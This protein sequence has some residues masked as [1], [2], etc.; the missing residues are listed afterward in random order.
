MENEAPN[1]VPAQ[2]DANKLSRFITKH[3]LAV[4]IGFLGA[5]ASIVALPIAIWF[6][7]WPTIPKGELTYAIQPVRTAFVQVSHPSD[8]TVLYKGKPIKGDLSAAQIMISNSGAQPIMANDI[9]VP[10]SIVVSNAEVL[11]CSFSTAPLSGSGFILATNLPNNHVNLGWDIF[12]HA[13]KPIIQIVYAGMRDAPIALEGRITDQAEPKEVSWFGTKRL[14]VFGICILTG[15]SMLMS[16]I[17]MIVFSKHVLP[18]IRT[19]GLSVPMFLV[20]GFIAGMV[21]FNALLLPIL[22]VLKAMGY[23][24]SPK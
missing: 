4:L 14:S 8:I 2:P 19:L 1:A 6:A 16:V 5:I 3:P 7:I 24:L 10:I 13:N 22:L 9:R 17:G 11:E 12:E 18:A 21:V 20:I 15:V 23:D